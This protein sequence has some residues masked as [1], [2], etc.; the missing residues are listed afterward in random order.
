[1]IYC[2]RNLLYS[3]FPHD[4]QA[5]VASLMTI[6]SCRL[7]INFAFKNILLTNVLEIKRHGLVNLKPEKDLFKTLLQQTVC[8]DLRK[9]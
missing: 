2:Y 9:P 6:L 1:M 4:F 7:F 8:L 3:F 5:V